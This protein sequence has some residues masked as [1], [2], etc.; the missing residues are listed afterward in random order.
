MTVV[1]RQRSRDSSRLCTNRG[2][3]VHR[4]RQEPSFRRVRRENRWNRG[5]HEG[6]I[7]AEGEQASGTGGTE[8]TSRVMSVPSVPPFGSTL[9]RHFPFEYRRYPL[10]RPEK[11]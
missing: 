1:R 11:R 10:Y 7:L 8:P 4:S 9:I 2:S 5:N 6:D 3:L